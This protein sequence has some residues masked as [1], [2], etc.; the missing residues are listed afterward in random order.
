LL[1][2]LSLHDALPICRRL[3]RSRNARSP[4]CRISGTDGRTSSGRKSRSEKKKIS[5]EF[6]WI[7][8]DLRLLQSIRKL[9]A[10]LRDL[11]RD[12]GAKIGR[13][14]VRAEVVLLVLLPA[15]DSG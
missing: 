13:A 2:P 7:A 11:R 15:V 6:R 4:Y 10:E 3:G 14:H 1:Y 8:F 5:R 9:L 12:D